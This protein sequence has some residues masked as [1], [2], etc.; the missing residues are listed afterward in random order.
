MK[1]GKRELI[2]T[3]TTLALVA[4]MVYFVIRSVLL[5]RADYTEADKMFSVL[6]LLGEAL[7]CCTGSGTR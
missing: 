1:I 6:L 3:M 2:N 4:I 7:F 5:L